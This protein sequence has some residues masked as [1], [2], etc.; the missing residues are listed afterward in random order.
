MNIKKLAGRVKKQL[1]NGQRHL[2]VGEFVFDLKDIAEKLENSRT[3]VIKYDLSNHG[4]KHIV[5][6]D[7][8]QLKSKLLSGMPFKY[9]GKKFHLKSQFGSTGGNIVK[10]IKYLVLAGLIVGVIWYVRKSLRK[11]A[12]AVAHALQNPFKTI[13]FD[14]RSEASVK[15]QAENEKRMKSQQKTFKEEKIYYEFMD[16][17][18]SEQKNAENKFSIVFQSATGKDPANAIIKLIKSI[19]QPWKKVIYREIGNLLKGY[20]VKDN[21]DAYNE[22]KEY[23]HYDQDY[24]VTVKDKLTGEKWSEVYLSLWKQGIKLKTAEMKLQLDIKRRKYGATENDMNLYFASRGYGHD[25]P[26]RANLN[27]LA[28][29]IGAEGFVNT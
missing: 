5:E 17:P 15:A 23:L 26:T 18:T 14:I 4:G 25:Y 19:P 28:V 13:G 27:K 7:S 6:M 22:L 1:E 10:I 20:G 11:P 3:G 9:C 12:E 2:Q 21:T 24:W 16:V 8:N 29:E